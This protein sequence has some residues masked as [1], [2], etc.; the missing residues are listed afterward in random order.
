[1]HVEE[2]ERGADDGKRQG[3]AAEHGR[4]AI[5]APRLLAVDEEAPDEEREGE[6]EGEGGVAD[7]AHGGGDVVDGGAPEITL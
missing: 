4:A 5:G 2:V 7:V 6:E 1:M 3:R